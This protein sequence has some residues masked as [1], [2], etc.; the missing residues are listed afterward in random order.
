MP[1]SPFPFPFPAAPLPLRAAPF[2]FP[3]ASDCPCMPRMLCF[4][5]HGTGVSMIVMNRGRIEEMG[6]ADEM[7]SNPKTEYTKKLIEAIPTG[8]I[9][10]I[11]LAQELKSQARAN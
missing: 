8:S 7:Y 2:P 6:D 5:F 11:K 10:A 4:R 9:E 3:A 1:A